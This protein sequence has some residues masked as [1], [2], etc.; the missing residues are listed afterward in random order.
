MIQTSAFLIAKRFIGLKEVPGVTANAQILAML[1]LEQPTEQ[2]DETAWC[3]AFANY[4]AW[5]LA[6]PRS[7]SL[8]A[9]SWLNVGAPIAPG[10]AEIGGDI[11][12][13]KRGPD[14]QPG[15]EVINAPGHVGFFAGWFDPKQT[16]V[17]ILGG[18]QKADGEVCVE[19]FPSSWILG[20]RRLA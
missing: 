9:R 8:A 14:P 16:R 4:V 5:L 17:L 18:N 12:V 13:L 6:L 7:N 3:S 20:V 19:S 1:Q 10:A 15:P 11:V 2:S